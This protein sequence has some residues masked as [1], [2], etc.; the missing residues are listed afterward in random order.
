MPAYVPNK[1]DELDVEVANVVNGFP[2]GLTFERVDPI[3][4]GTVAKASAP[5]S[6]EEVRGQYAISNLLSRKVVTCRLVLVQRGE[7][8]G[9][10]KVMVRVGGGTCAF[11]VISSRK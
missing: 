10:R 1:S 6:G 7:D 2:H 11:T 9:G 8:A 5:G 4:K 3:R